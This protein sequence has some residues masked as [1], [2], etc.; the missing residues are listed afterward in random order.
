MKARVKATNEVVDVM[1]EKNGY[2]VDYENNNVYKFDDLDFTYKEENQFQD[3]FTSM[4]SSFINTSKDLQKDFKE[5][6][7]VNKFIEVFFD[8]FKT[9]FGCDTLKNTFDDSLECTKKLMEEIKK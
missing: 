3:P 8:F 4:L 6:F 5:Q 2:F 1:P 9:L 7:Y